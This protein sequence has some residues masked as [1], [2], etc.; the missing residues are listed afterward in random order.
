MLYVPAVISV[1]AFGLS[2]DI[3]VNQYNLIKTASG[4]INLPVKSLWTA[5]FHVYFTSYTIAS[6]L[7]IFRWK[8]NNLHNKNIRDLANLFLVSFFLAFLLAVLT[9]LMSASTTRSPL[10]QITPLFGL[11]PVAVICHAMRQGE[12]PNYRAKNK[13]LLSLGSD[14]F[15][16][17]YNYIG[18]SFVVGGLASILSYQFPDLLSS[19]ESARAMLSG[20]AAMFL[21]GVSILLAQ[22]ISDTKI[23]D[24]VAL[25]ITLFS[26]P[27]VTMQFVGYASITVWVLPLV[28][29]MASLVFRSRRHLILLT[30]V[31]VA[32]QILVWSNAPEG[33]VHIDEFDFILRIIVL[34]VACA[35][36]IFVNVTYN[37]EIKDNAF[38]LN[39]QRL[40]SEVSVDFVTINQMNME[41]KF[42]ALLEKIG[43]FFHVDRTY[44]FLIDEVRNTMTYAYEWCNEGISPEVELIQD[45]PVDVFPWWMD[46][47]S[48][49]KLVQVEDVDNL[50]EEAATEKEILKKQGVKSVLVLPIGHEGP[51]L[52]FIGLDSV[53]S[54]KRWIAYHIEMLQ[55]LSHLAADALIRLESEKTIEHLAYN[56]HLTG[57]PNRVSFSDHLSQAVHH[58]NRS[59]KMMAVLFLDL[60]GF[61][62]I[63]DTMGHSGGD[64][65]LVEI[66]KRLRSSLNKA[67][68]VSRFGGDE[69]IILINNLD[70]ETEAV[71]VA[72]KVM[73]AFKNSFY[74]YDQE[75]YVSASGGLSIFPFH[76]KDPETLIMN[77]DL[78]MYRAKDRGKNQYIMFTNNMKE[79][80]ERNTK[81]S[82]LLYS[83]L[84]KNELFLHYQPQ[85]KVCTGEI[86][87][88]EALLRWN[89]PDFG[90][91]SP[92]VF[93]PIAET[94]GTINSIGEWV[95]KTAVQKNKEWQDK[96]FPP[97]RVSV[98]LSIV[99]FRNPNL[100]NRIVSIL[101]ESGLEPKYLELEITE[102]VAS[103]D[104]AQVQRT[105]KQLRD[106]GVTIS[107]DDF[108]MEYSS[109]DRLK[110]LPIDR[111]KIDMN[112]VQG[113]EINEKDQAITKIIINLAKSLGLKV[114]AEGVETAR[115]LQFLNHKKCDEVQGYY[116]YR[117]MAA[118]GVEKLFKGEIPKNHCCLRKQANSPDR[119]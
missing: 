13:E 17:I 101:K 22:L 113:I 33:A 10:S 71:R 115:Q 42:A 65:L 24:L 106:L 85:V 56:D 111:I 77:A 91:I 35:I 87:G 96:G 108:G 105:L 12:P 19:P 81:L 8:K 53:L 104:S 116:C 15:F 7:L 52:G 47:L 6:L 30:A 36:G 60:D 9:D 109:L 21:A 63:N 44:I 45:V 64:T 14:V 86:V 76:G 93:I 110:A 80:M 92:A 39:F 103:K 89:N 69:F 40:V 61:K 54:K 72:D 32:T 68:T 95:L 82:S 59:K 112:F 100:V 25:I 102:S 18:L 46:E 78:A 117:P 5:F 16:K 88:F 57:L 48:V 75:F 70:D 84:E 74:V 90:M 49:N 107:I 3:A 119:E 79:E 73:D 4:W 28:L 58:A 11:F 55:L 23:K 2:G 94:N 26:I 50:P 34:L 99:Q 43:Q 37:N 51:M 1:Y 83:V 97:V 38:Q 66:S 118:D 41:E 29:M 20:G 27:L 98:N 114:L 67:D 31:S 62:M